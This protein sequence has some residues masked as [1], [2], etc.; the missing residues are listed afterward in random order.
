MSD[1]E[2]A[3][4]EMSM[5]A[6]YAHVIPSM[7]IGLLDLVHDMTMRLGD[8]LEVQGKVVEEVKQ[9]LAR[10]DEEGAEIITFPPENE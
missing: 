3:E 5:E 7:W 8:F 2:E 1:E 10:N 4:D 9:H 6:F